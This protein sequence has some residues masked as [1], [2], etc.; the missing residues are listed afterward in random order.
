MTGD[1]VFHTSLLIYSIMQMPRSSAVE[2]P[3]AS[4]PGRSDRAVPVVSTSE[5]LLE[6]RVLLLH[7]VLG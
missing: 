5:G 6:R 2:R 3:N 7:G 4:N 1:R